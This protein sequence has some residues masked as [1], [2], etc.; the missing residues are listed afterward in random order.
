MI[1]FPNVGGPFFTLGR[2][3]L[4]DNCDRSPEGRKVGWEKAVQGPACLRGLST[5][6]FYDQLPLEIET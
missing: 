2:G 6:Y 1:L 3:L 5:E 4:R